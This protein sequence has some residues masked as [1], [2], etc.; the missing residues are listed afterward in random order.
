MMKR[1]MEELK[2][3]YRVLQFAHALFPKI[4]SKDI[5]WAV[6]HLSS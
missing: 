2:M 5:E 6:K 4:E 1:R 3:V